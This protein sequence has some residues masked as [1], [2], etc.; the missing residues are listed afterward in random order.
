MPHSTEQTLDALVCIA[1]AHLHH[2][3]ARS[4]LHICTPVFLSSLDQLL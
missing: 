1:I 4:P 3:P 2:G